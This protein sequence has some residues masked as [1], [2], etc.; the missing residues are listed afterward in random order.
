MKS[1]QFAE[2]A[3]KKNTSQN[4]E[5]GGMMRASYDV[6]QKRRVHRHQSHKITQTVVLAVN[7]ECEM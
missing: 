1:Q 3:D 7:H 4:R 5:S 2:E 6:R